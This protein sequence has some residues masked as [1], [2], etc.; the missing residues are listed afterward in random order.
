MASTTLLCAFFL[1]LLSC[2]RSERLEEPSTSDMQYTCN[3]IAAAISSASQVFFP[4]ATEY[5]FDIEHYSYSN[6]EASACSV[7]P[8]SAADLSE[9][10]RVLGSSRTPFAVKGGGHGVNPGFSST[11]GV[12]IAMSRFNETHVNSTCGTVEV[13]A[14]LT[15]DEVYATLGPTGVN[16]VGAR[17]PGVGV[18]G[19]ALGGGYSYLSNQY[20]LMVDNVIRYE[21]VLP[22]GTVTN[23]TSNDDDLWFGLKGG[24]NNFGI[25]TK[26]IFQ[27]HPQGGI[28]G[29]FRLHA[30][31]QLDAIK[32]A[33]VKFQQ[34]N[35]TKAAIDVVLSYSSGQLSIAVLFFYDE[36]TSSGVFDDFLAIPA[37]EANVSTTTFS[38]FIQLLG[39]LV[40]ANGLRVLFEGAPVTQ[41]SPAVFDAFANQTKLWGAR[42]SALDKNATVSSTLEPFDNGFFSFGSG[43]AFPPDR[44]QAVFPSVVTVKWSNASLEEVMAFAL[45]NISDTIRA[46]ALADGQNVAHAAVYPNNALFGTPLEDMY[47]GNVERLRQ[48][49][50]AIDPEDVMGLTGGWRF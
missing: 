7:E 21:L 6:T 8:G 20:G 25:V 23:V 22:N 33:L 13:G 28:W 4:P 42:L 19:S 18:A 2:S 27:S 38:D 41:Y 9:I 46:A 30:E 35:D 24:L 11:S 40:A 1:A 34:K 14:G 29:G 50:A 26:F 39:P 48:I 36:P 47:G 32:D 37:I 31:N 16:L 49:R 12:E 10:L 5:L 17:A 43:S 3:Q 44:S 45:R 15:W